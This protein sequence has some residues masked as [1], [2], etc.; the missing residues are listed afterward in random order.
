MPFRENWYFC[1]VI[2]D[3]NNYENNL[4]VRDYEIENA[5][6]GDTVRHGS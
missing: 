6:D 3:I 2:V 5:V 1:Y 4:L